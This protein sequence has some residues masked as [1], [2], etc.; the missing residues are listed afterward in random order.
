MMDAQ[1]G[2]TEPQINQRHKER[3]RV[4]MHLA[5]WCEAIPART[6]QGPSLTAPTLTEE[7]KAAARKK[8]EQR[9]R[10]NKA[11]R[12]N[13]LKVALRICYWYADYLA[14]YDLPLDEEPEEP[15]MRQ[16]CREQLHEWR[17]LYEG[18]ESFTLATQLW[19]K[20]RIRGR[21]GDSIAALRMKHYESHGAVPNRG[22]TVRFSSQDCFSINP[23]FA[24]CP[25]TLKMAHDGRAHHTHATADR[26]PGE[27][28]TAPPRDEVPRRY[29]AVE[30]L[31]GCTS[32]PNAKLIRETYR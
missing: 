30:A 32:E 11:K 25:C 4:V 22:E 18:R 31:D 2:K 27:I 16:H 10:A 23:A 26:E 29:T 15:L 6:V 8:G 19:Y 21:I 7:E 20:E 12:R 5:V 17:D 1:R 3:L 28:G 13:I 9:Y 24:M 14:S